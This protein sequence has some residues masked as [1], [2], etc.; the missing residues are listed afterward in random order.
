MKVVVLLLLVSSAIYSLPFRC[1]H[2]VTS[3]YGSLTGYGGERR[4]CGHIGI[5][6][7]PAEWDYII[8]PI[9]AGEVTEVGVS[10][11]YGKYVIVQH[12]ETTRSLYAHGE[13]IYS[14]AV[15]LVDTTTPIMR[16]GNTG[17]SDG[18]HL[19]LE[20]HKLINGRWCPVDPAPF[21]HLDETSY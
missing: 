17:F 13:I 11:V 18:A 6:L 9:M 12:D 4:A 16:M 21:L 20:I 7:I 5:D 3:E 10:T 1:D 2:V 15:G 19:H 14:T 8:F